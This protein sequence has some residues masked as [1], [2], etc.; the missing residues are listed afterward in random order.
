MNTIFF[1]NMA[2]YNLG[3][4]A[5]F[6]GTVNILRNTI[7]PNMEFVMPSRH[8]LSDRKRLEDLDGIHLV[9]MSFYQG[10][11]RL[12]LRKAN[13]LKKY[14]TPR[15]SPNTFQPNHI[16]AVLSVGGDMYTLYNNDLPWDLVK[17]GDYCIS[18]KVPYV[19]WGASMESFEKRPELVET[20]VTHLKS[21][22]LITARDKNTSEYLEKYGIINN[23]SNVFDPAFCMEPISCDIEKYMPMRKSDVC[24]G[25]NLSPL[26]QRYQK[27]PDLAI[28]TAK[29]VELW[30]EKT[31]YSVILVSHVFS[32]FNDSGYDDRMFHEHV[33]QL[34][35]P[36]YR[37]FIGNANEDIGSP[38]MKYLISQL[39]GYAGTRMHST[40][41]SFSMSVPTICLAYSE[42]AYGL[43]NIFFQHDNWVLPISNFSPETCVNKLI[44]LVSV[45]HELRLYL[46][47]KIPAIKNG[48]F[49]GGSLLKSALGSRCQ[50]L[51]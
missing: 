5:I 45:R 20:L 29:T 8:L 36:K 19:I 47:N 33:Y 17:M 7:H 2:L 22:L 41:A 46:Q 23:V 11:K 24:I 27:R 35:A 26:S 4:E 48:A 39:D 50:C 44:E 31:G 37:P 15:F 25:L 49:K 18:Q 13:L 1:T 40:V 42:K 51:S 43:N 9:P 3:C 16:L 30:V 32:P 12:F 6:R 14:W 38:R 21:C 10:I 34:I 28:Q